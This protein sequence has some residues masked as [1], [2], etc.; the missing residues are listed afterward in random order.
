[1][2]CSKS[3]IECLRDKNVQPH[4]FANYQDS[5]NIASNAIDYSTS[6]YFDSQN[7][8]LSYEHWW[9]VDFKQNVAIEKY[10][11][12][13]SNSNGDKLYSWQAYASNDSVTYD[14]IDSPSAG[15]P[16]GKIYTLSSPKTMRY[17]K[18]IGFNVNTLKCFNMEYIKFYIYGW[19]KRD[20]F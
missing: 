11:I 9:A 20:E 8:A 5:T 14:I 19:T 16:N 12:K 15:Y 18:I 10:Q 3:I 13:E 6:N 4:A 17:F 2:A 7:A 1:M